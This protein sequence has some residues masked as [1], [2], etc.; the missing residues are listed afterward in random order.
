M[1]LGATTIWDQ[2]W[3]SKFLIPYSFYSWQNETRI[4]IINNFIQYILHLY[5]LYTF[6]C[7]VS[8]NFELNFFKYMIHGNMEFTCPKIFWTFE[9]SNI[10][11]QPI[12]KEKFTLFDIIF[13]LKVKVEPKTLNCIFLNNFFFLKFGCAKIVEYLRYLITNWSPY[14]KKISQYLILGTTFSLKVNQNCE[15]FFK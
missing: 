4:F 7:E 1:K 5:H 10:N 11:L 6:I 3:G 2:N 8:Q 9:V 13:T 12:S 15:F 14:L